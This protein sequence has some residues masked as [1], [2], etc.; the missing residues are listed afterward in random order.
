MIAQKEITTENIDKYWLNKYVH[1]N[2]KRKFLAFKKLEETIL[3]EMA[4]SHICAI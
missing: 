4:K 1:L 3:T 2:L